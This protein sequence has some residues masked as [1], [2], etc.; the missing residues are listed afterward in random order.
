MSYF[1]TS[2]VHFLE[3]YIYRSKF[4]INKYKNKQIILVTIDD[5]TIGEIGPYPF[6]RSEYAKAIE[7]ILKGSPKV[8]GVDIFFDGIKDLKDDIKLIDVLDR[9]DTNIVLAI[10]PE[11]AD[12]LII[13]KIKSLSPS[14]SYNYKNISVGDVEIF[15]G[16]QSTG[17][18]KISAMSF[19]SRQP[20]KEFLPFPIAV[21]SKFLKVDYKLKFLMH[22]SLVAIIGN[23]EIP[24]VTKNRTSGML[25]N[26]VGGVDAFDTI[27][28]EK[29]SESD[30][31]MFNNKIVLIGATA[32]SIGDNFITPLS[33]KTPG[34][35][36]HANAIYTII[37]NKFISEVGL[38]YQIIITF[39]VCLAISTL[40]YF[41]KPLTSLSISI[42]ILIAYKII[43]DF[44][45][46]KY[47]LYF[48]YSPL[49]FS[50]L[51]SNLGSFIWIRL[52][53][54]TKNWAK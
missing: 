51:L 26:Y 9:A 17:I 16:S 8:I 37:N 41:L 14:R 10:Y 44:I 53:G 48:L 27:P 28:F 1:L 21:T 11:E 40:V 33:K 4:P 5:K 43:I 35:V 54:R 34:V 20:E 38:Q 32:E 15:I 39:F 31:S 36:I 13:N 45:F 3:D 22:D 52:K 49:F 6:R 24:V 2:R 25:I 50:V 29:I 46:T 47:R 30:S 23:R 42:F 12:N 7:K 19:I 18:T